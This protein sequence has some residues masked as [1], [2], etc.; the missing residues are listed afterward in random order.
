MM[1]ET[2]VVTVEPTEAK[3][4]VEVTHA[5]IACTKAIDMSTRVTTAPATATTAMMAMPR[6]A[7]GDSRHCQRRRDSRNE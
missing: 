3:V 7:N 6:P 2:E 1:A 5:H 4:A